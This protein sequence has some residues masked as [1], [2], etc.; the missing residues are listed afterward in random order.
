[1][2][3]ISI[4]MPVFNDR[5]FLRPAIESLLAQ[6]VGDFELILSD[7]GSTDG[8]AEIC[9]EYAV[10]D[11]RIRYIRQEVNLGI[12]RNM[13][14]LLRESRGEFFMWA[15]DDD[16]W[17]SDFL[18]KLVA[19]LRKKAAA[20]VA[21]CPYRFI[22]DTGEVIREYPAR[23][24]DY[25]GDSDL[26][27]LRKLIRLFDDGFG[28]GLFRR[29]MILDVEFPVWWGINRKTAYNNIYP[30][31]CFYLTKGD[32]VL[33]GEETL[34]FNRIKRDE[35]VHH[36]LPF[37]KSYLRGATAFALRKFNLFWVS[38]GEVV[39]AG[40]GRLLAIRILPELFYC[41]FL[42]PSLVNYCLQFKQWRK[43]HLSFF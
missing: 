34:W 37:P 25:S 9:R 1:M 15:A 17:A 43:G 18:E 5:Q 24:I 22:D 41:W 42:K 28:Y 6:T 31:L 12:S 38:L 23:V 14:F 27:R 19:G 2:P 21:F 33:C 4:G 3:L 20:I 39:R 40:G 13:K 10:R 11:P 35:N 36:K 32:F 26:V 30:T 8:S 16:V 7:D 29:E